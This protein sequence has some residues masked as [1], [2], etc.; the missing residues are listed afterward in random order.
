MRRRILLL[1]FLVVPVVCAG[2]FF[3]LR[4]G[5]AMGRESGSDTD[6]E[7][8]APN[9]V[10]QVQIVRIERMPSILYFA[11]ASFRSWLFW[12]RGQRFHPGAGGTDACCARP[13]DGKK[14]ATTIAM[15]NTIH[16]VRIF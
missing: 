14:T 11:Q 16:R 4:T 5:P 6:T 10:A 13:D 15:M 12:Q 3:L 2:L 1:G 8:G 9:P 7:A